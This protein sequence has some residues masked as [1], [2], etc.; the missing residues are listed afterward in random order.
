MDAGYGILWPEEGRELSC[1][2]QLAEDRGFETV[3]QKEEGQRLFLELR[4][5]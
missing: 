3:S 1:Y 4:K 5:P 2:V